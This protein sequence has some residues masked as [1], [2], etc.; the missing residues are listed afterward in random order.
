MAPLSKQ[1]FRDLIAQYI[2]RNSNHTKAAIARHFVSYGV[3]RST[4]YAII[5]KF[6]TRGDVFHAGKGRIAKKMPTQLRKKLIRTANWG[7]P[8]DFWLESLAYPK[9]TCN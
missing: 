1:G 2:Q 7:S 4:V 9:P 6:Q 3:A 5:D 8:S